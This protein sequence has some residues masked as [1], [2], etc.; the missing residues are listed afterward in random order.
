MYKYIYSWVYENS[1][2]CTL[3]N[4]HTLTHAHTNCI[5]VY[6]YKKSQT[7]GL[8]RNSNWTFTDTNPRIEEDH[9]TTF[10]IKVR[11]KDYLHHSQYLD[12]DVKSKT[13]VEHQY[14]K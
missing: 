9:K 1:Y 6:K 14:M 7:R 11:T 2:E 5:F 13:P 10:A 8:R 12:E 3:S 4:T